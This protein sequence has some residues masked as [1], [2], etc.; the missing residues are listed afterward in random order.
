MDLRGARDVIHVVAQGN[1]EVEE[2]LRA[3]AEHLQLHGA[4]PL[5]GA[6]AADDQGQVVGPKLRVGLW[7]VCVGVPRRREDCGGLD[8]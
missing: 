1:E 8:S 3:A 7:R 6:A 5:E 4:A 2:Q